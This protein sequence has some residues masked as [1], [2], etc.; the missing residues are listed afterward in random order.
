MENI[1]VTSDGRGVVCLRDAR[2]A[3]GPLKN[4]TRE[5]IVQLVSNHFSPQFHDFTPVTSITRNSLNKGQ[6]S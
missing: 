6:I 3:F 4:R 5:G 2:M 1:F